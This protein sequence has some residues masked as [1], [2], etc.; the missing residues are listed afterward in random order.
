MLSENLQLYE[1]KSTKASLKGKGVGK[2]TKKTYG[3]QA[4][5]SPSPIAHCSSAF[6]SIEA[7]TN[8]L[9][10]PENV[11]E[12]PYQ[13][14]WGDIEIEKIPV[15]LS[16]DLQ[17]YEEIIIPYETK[18]FNETHVS[19]ETDQIRNQSDQIIES[20]NGEAST[21]TENAGEEARKIKDT[22]KDDTP[23]KKINYTRPKI[24]ITSDTKIT[25]TQLEQLRL[26]NQNKTNN[27]I[28]K[29]MRQVAINKKI[30]LPPKKN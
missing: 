12:S 22:N 24:I 29:T 17:L 13:E 20:Q 11:D 6:K 23:N 27:K 16:E 2:R 10:P 19:E 5:N 28:N 4:N 14:Y 15:I 30:K 3:E 21:S 7:K 25:P 1:K 26:K 9:P 8:N 18:D